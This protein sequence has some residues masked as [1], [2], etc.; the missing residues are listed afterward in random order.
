MKF[1]LTNKGNAVNSDY[2]HVANLLQNIMGK[3]SSPLAAIESFGAG[4]NLTKVLLEQPAASLEA[5]SDSASEE[6][7][8][9][10]NS[11]NT[12]HSAIVEAATQYGEENNPGLESYQLQAGIE[13]AI[14]AL[15]YK[16]AI[17]AEKKMPVISNESINMGEFNVS[18]F[19]GT[20]A[21]NPFSPANEAF[22]GQ[23]LEGAVKYSM[24]FNIAVT[25][26]DAF[27]EL[28]FPILLIDHNTAAINV[29]VTVP[30]IYE[31]VLIPRDGKAAENRF[32]KRP[33]I[34]IYRDTSLLR[35]EEN[36]LIPHLDANTE[37][38]LDKDLA[39]VNKEKGVDITTA[40]LLAGEERPI[41]YMSQTE[42]QL[43]EGKHDNT[44][45]MDRTIRLTN[46]YLELKGTVG[47]NAVTEVIKYDVSKT[48]TNN[49]TFTTQGHSKELAMQF[50]ASDIVIN[51]SNT[52]LW[53]GNAS[54]ILDTLPTN[55]SVRLKLMLAGD[56]NVETGNVAVY[57]K[58]SIKILDIKNAAGSYIVESDPVYTTIKNTIENNLK[59]RSYDVDAWHT[60]SNLRNT[61]TLTGA[62]TFNTLYSVQVRSGHA[63]MEPA[64][65]RPNIDN[66]VAKAAI[67]AIVIGQRMTNEAYFTLEKHF[68]RLEEYKESGRLEEIEFIG[69]SVKYG[70][71][72]WYKR[73]TIHLPDVVSTFRT[74]DKLD[75][76]QKALEDIIRINVM[77]MY[78]ESGFD[79]ARL[80]YTGNKTDRATVAIG[81]DQY[82]ES[83]LIK[84]NGLNLGPKFDTEIVSSKLPEIRNKMFITFVEDSSERHTKISPLTFGKCLFRPTI[85]ADMQV[86]RNGSYRKELITSPSYLHF[87]QLPIGL[88][89]EVT[90]LNEI[91]SGHTLDI[92]IKNIVKTNEVTL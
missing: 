43:A 15:D 5:F 92:N 77:D 76:M 42:K 61:G 1:D 17:T 23:N 53:N 65:N 85:A 46:I 40:P 3:G 18:T 11:A 68:A 34:K 90:G 33:L 48:P 28:F 13:A 88:M 54:T 51:T 47:G 52:S 27:S 30:N 6:V 36:R 35:L 31:S 83:Y 80:M 84:N 16:S 39:T 49:F 10:N 67:S 26:Q 63:A 79:V 44:D 78:I 7:I 75:D 86:R 72:P 37:S 74:V 21:N 73:L 2:G 4:N 91:L 55:H 87:T 59:F 81:T 29:E 32:N 50:S 14:A 62:D 56:A 22:D 89:I 20:V 57:G 60:N 71:T 25:K 64:S 82:I 19:G 8:T 24:G 66:D 12:L 45:A 9:L 58:G 38:A 69:L 70:I 41:L